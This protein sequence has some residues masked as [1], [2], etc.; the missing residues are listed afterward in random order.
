MAVNTGKISA[1]WHPDQEERGSSLSAG[2]VESR[3]LT[4]N[5]REEISDRGKL[6]YE[7]KAWVGDR[8]WKYF[9]RFKR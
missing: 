9:L 3:F 8:W 5:L 4:L 2:G 7:I 1:W 6:N